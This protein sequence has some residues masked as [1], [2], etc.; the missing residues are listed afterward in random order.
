M[1]WQCKRGGE[2]ES[3]EPGD[4]LF[5]RWQV[6]KIAAVF[7]FL[8]V[9]QGSNGSKKKKLEMFRSCL[10]NGQTPLLK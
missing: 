10:T 2:R 7:F 4:P 3:F 8:A 6:L 1:T 5:P 9:E